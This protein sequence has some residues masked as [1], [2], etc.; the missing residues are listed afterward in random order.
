MMSVSALPAFAASLTDPAKAA[1]LVPHKAL[2]EIRLSS[3]KSGSQII[4]IHGQMLY[5][6]QASCDA[7]TSDQRFNLSYEYADSPAMSVISDFS[8]YE[9]F[10]G[11]T[12][13]FTSQK[14]QDGRVFEEIRGQATHNDD[15]SGVAVFTMPAGKTLDL[16]K[17]T[18]FP[19]MRT[20]EL[21]KAM[22][23][24][25]KFYTATTFDGGD[26]EG[27]VEVNAFI[28]K[29]VTVAI[30]PKLS[31]NVDAKLTEA[32]ARQIRLAFF[33]LKNR[34]ESRADYEMTATFHDNGIISDM[35]VDYDDF[36]VKQSLIALEA[37]KA[38]S[39]CG[40]GE[41]TPP[42]PEKGTSE[43]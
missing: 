22:K 27:A 26:A 3:A 38:D 9:S 21:I 25:E 32:P 8:T 13:N 41:K 42:K 30:D 33:P 34:G 10:D 2:Y 11:K 31:P 23:A 16:S 17:G 14:K 6:W 15:G 28:G 36:S 12:M 39:S 43:N 19:M 29:P 18:L 7:W 35:M 1:G 20:L 40:T 37:Y 4:N 5:E 24:G